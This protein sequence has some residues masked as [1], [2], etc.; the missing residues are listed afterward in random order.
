MDEDRVTV[1]EAAERLGVKEQ[2]VR[3]R[4]SRGTLRSDKDEDGRV[5]VYIPHT[6]EDIDEDETAPDALVASLQDQIAYLRAQLDAEREARTEERRRADTVIAQQAQANA[7]MSRTI[8]AIEAPDSLRDEQQ[9]A[10]S[11]QGGTPEGSTTPETEEANFEPRRGWWSRI[12][13]R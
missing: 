7:E 6:P 8:R 10:D 4:I 11:G 9:P 2:T 12:F 5:H 1:A 3:K 13:G